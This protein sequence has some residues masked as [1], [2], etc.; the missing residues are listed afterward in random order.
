MGTK[1]RD[2]I[3][4]LGGAAVMPFAARAQQPEQVRR[5]GVLM[6]LAANDPEGRGMSAAF[7]QGMSQLGWNQGSNLHI[8]WRWAAGDGERLRTYAAELATLRP[9]VILLNGT[10]ALTA[11]RQHTQ[12]TP[13]VF[14]NVGDPVGSGL[15]ASLA[16]PGGHIT[17]F[18]NYEYSMGGKWL[19]LLKEV[20]PRVTRCLAVFN[21]ENAAHKGLLQ[22]VEA[23]ASSAAIRLAPLD[24][25][26]PSNIEAAVDNFAKE[27]NGGLIVLPDF[28]TTTYRDRIIDSAARNN[29]PGVF[30]F[31]SFAISG[32]LLVYAVDSF[33]LYRRGAASYADRILRGS[34]PGQLPVQA[35]TKFELVIN[36]KTAKALGITVPATLLARADEVIE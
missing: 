36:L 3:A 32:G 21:S 29:L 4:V 16:R 5:I 14:V 24:I 30:P 18:T 17:G 12:T 11:V 19:E 27:A 34:T 9:D 35:P 7:V 23:V 10:P 22:A 20:T 33:E 1:R 26:N 2:F 31:R 8:E 25:S 28:R 13:I 15:I 6:S